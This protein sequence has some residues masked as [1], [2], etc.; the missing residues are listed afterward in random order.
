MNGSYK[1]NV[2]RSHEDDNIMNIYY[3]YIVCPHYIYTTHVHATCWL[4]GF[5][6]PF[7]LVITGQQAGFR[8]FLATS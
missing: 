7:S 1:I 8:G 2:G 3:E 4:A 5:C 6:W